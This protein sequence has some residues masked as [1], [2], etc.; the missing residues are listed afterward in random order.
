MQ[1]DE[2][3][4]KE[5]EAK[6]ND[7]NVEKEIKEEIKR[8][9]KIEDCIIRAITYD[10]GNFIEEHPKEYQELKKGVEEGTGNVLDVIG[11]ITFS[12]ADFIELVEDDQT[13]IENDVKGAKATIIYDIKIYLGEDYRQM[14]NIRG[15]Y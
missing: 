15:E 13:V 6:T 2:I 5:A 12:H 9:D 14:C 3:Q 1:N 7:I 4:T 8:N 10:I 11:N